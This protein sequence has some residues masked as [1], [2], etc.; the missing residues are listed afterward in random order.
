MAVS[1][2]KFWKMLI[3]KKIKAAEIQRLAGVSGNILTRMRRDEYI[4]IESIEK[5]CN[6]L[7]CGVA[8]IL[9]FV[10][11]EEQRGK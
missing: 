6:V 11:I 3:D 9:D 7:H 5:I 2:N 8:D 1:Y 10:P 4:S